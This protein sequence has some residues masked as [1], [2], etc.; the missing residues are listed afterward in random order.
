MSVTRRRVGVMRAG[1]AGSMTTLKVKEV[2]RRRREGLVV[3][4]VGPVA[5]AGGWEWIVAVGQKVFQ[6]G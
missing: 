2:P 6:V 1:R 5:G 4:V 3:A